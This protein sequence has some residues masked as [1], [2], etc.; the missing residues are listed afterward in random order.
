MNLGRGWP[1][2]RSQVL[3]PGLLM[4]PGVARLGGR[5]LVQMYGGGRYPVIITTGDGAFHSWE[6]SVTDPG[7][8]GHA[9]RLEATLRQGSANPVGVTRAS[10]VNDGTIPP[11]PLRGS[12][13]GRCG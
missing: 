4:D 8:L 10:A 12:H 9:D 6:V 1:P 7:P 2:F 11:V 3:W 5:N 13:D